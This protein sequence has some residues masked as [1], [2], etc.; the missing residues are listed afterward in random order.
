MEILSGLPP[1]DHEH[2][3]AHH[4]PPRTTHPDAAADYLRATRATAAVIAEVFAER[5]RQDEVWGEQNH[6][7]GTGREPWPSA[8]RLARQVCKA[9]AS[10]GVVT[11]FDIA[12]EEAFEAFAETDPVRLRAE[13]IQAAAVFAAWA[14]AIDRRRPGDPVHERLGGSS[15]PS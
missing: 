2:P 4:R 15:V 7:D 9:R 10:A 1:A 6:P 3:R 12:R 5:L 13:L 8:A 14:E 11:W